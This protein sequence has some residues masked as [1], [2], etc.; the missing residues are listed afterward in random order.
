MFRMSLVYSRR[1]V[2]ALRPVCFPVL[3]FEHSFLL[4]IAAADPHKAPLTLAKLQDSMKRSVE[5]IEKDIRP[6][7]RTLGKYSKALDK[8][9]RLSSPGY[10]ALTR[11][12]RSSKRDPSPQLTMTPSPPTPTS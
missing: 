6:I 8:V 9:R 5:A 10:E 3:L 1:L 12:I 4:T 7:Y 2:L 11:S